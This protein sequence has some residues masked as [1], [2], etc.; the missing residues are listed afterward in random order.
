VDHGAAVAKM[1]QHM[2]QAWLLLYGLQ[3]LQLVPSLVSWVRTPGGSRRASGAVDA[4]CAS[5][6]AAHCLALAGGGARAYVGATFRLGRRGALQPLALRAAA[7]YLLA[8]SLVGQSVRSFH[9]AAAAAGAVLFGHWAAEAARALLL[10]AAAAASGDVR[11]FAS[12]KRK[13][14]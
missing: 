10:W 5:L 13:V 4:L 9:V 7:A 11:L 8:A 12:G 2:H 3:L 14:K 1:L 6:M